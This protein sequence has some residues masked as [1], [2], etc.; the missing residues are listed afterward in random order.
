MLGKLTRVVGEEAF[1]L[2][3]RWA[4]EE[5][6]PEIR[7]NQYQHLG[8]SDN[9]RAQP[10]VLTMFHLHEMLTSS[11]NTVEDMVRGHQL[12][13][14]PGRDGVPPPVHLRMQIQLALAANRYS[15]RLNPIQDDA[16]DEEE[17]KSEEEPASSR[18]GDQ[19]SGPSPS[20]QPSGPR[21]QR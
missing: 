8:V 19:P 2:W 17:E 3:L 10:G 6:L 1:K 7:P 15:G 16:E 12:A 18:A 5:D 20:T 14:R 4:G 13:R 9:D 21:N 11:R